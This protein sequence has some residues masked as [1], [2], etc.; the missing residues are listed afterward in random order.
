MT[1]W[2][3]IISTHIPW[4]RLLS[5]TIIPSNNDT[6]KNIVV[7]GGEGFLK[8]LMTSSIIPLPWLLGDKR[9]WAQNY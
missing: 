7:C 9:L 2:L 6:G 3:D 4:T 8:L 5:H 1:Q